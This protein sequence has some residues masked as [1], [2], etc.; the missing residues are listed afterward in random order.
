MVER[1]DRWRDFFAIDLVI[2]QPLLETFQVQDNDVFAL[3]SPIV[4][5]IGPSIVLL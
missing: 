1:I 4:S 2:N 3:Q 5:S